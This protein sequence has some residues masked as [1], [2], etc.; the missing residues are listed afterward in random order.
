MKN[1]LVAKRVNELIFISIFDIFLRSTLKRFDTTVCWFNFS[2]HNLDDYVVILE[3]FENLGKERGLTHSPFA[4]SSLGI[5]WQKCLF[6]L[7]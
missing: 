4:F 5:L 1:K 2:Q 6:C 3:F 7:G